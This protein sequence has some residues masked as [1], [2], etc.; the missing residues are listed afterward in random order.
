[1]LQPFET[2][3]QKDPILAKI[4]GQMA[5]ISQKVIIIFIKNLLENTTLCEISNA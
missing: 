4:L 2:L 1:M 3:W 5:C